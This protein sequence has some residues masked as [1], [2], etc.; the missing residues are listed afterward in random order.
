MSDVKVTIYEKDYYYPEGNAAEFM[1]FF[2]D[3]LDTIPKEFVDSAVIEIEAVDNYGSS[4]IDC[5][6]YYFRPQTEAEI[7]AEMAAKE[8]IALGERQRK[9]DQIERLKRELG[10]A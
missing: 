4:S 1:K 3:K 6:I 7:S 8:A 10:V 9:L 5:S 2:Q